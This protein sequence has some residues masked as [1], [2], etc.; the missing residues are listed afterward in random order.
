MCS[1]YP[2]PNSADMQ[3][4]LIQQLAQLFGRLRLHGL[5]KSSNGS[6]CPIDLDRRIS[7]AMPTWHQ[8]HPGKDLSARIL[9]PAYVT[10]VA[11]KCRKSGAQG[12]DLSQGAGI[13]H[14]MSAEEEGMKA[15]RE[16]NDAV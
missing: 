11:R 3:Q 4:Y 14:F 10:E 12:E 9:N 8:E 2:D 5:T 15:L 13:I 16:T 6:P 7:F 1:S